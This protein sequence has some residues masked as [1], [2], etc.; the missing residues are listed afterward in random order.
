MAAVYFLLA[1]EIDKNP[2][3][4][5]N[6]KGMDLMKIFHVSKEDTKV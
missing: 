2:F 4:L 1:S 3:T 5:F 6:L